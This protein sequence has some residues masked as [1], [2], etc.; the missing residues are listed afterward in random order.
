MKFVA[1]N[2]HCENSSTFDSD[3]TWV[4]NTEGRREITYF[5]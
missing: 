5:R 2:E 3:E 1:E 4:D